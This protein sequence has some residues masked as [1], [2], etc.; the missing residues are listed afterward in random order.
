MASIFSQMFPSKKGAYTSGATWDN[1]T[2][3]TSIWIKVFRDKHT[4]LFS[5]KFNIFP[6]LSNACQGQT[7]LLILKAVQQQ[8]K[9]DNIFLVIFVI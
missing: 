6:V 5:W 4:S 8:I 1:L 3:I 2:P 9:S 7:L